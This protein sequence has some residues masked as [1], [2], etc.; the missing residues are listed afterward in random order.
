MV[1]GSNGIRIDILIFTR[2]S[3]R[4]SV[5][6]LLLSINYIAEPCMFI[7]CYEGPIEVRRQPL[8]H[9]GTFEKWGRKYDD[10]RAE[11]Y[12]VI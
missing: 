9:L 11:E 4:L 1:W 2:Y 12:N 7:G 8:L 10:Y 5:F 6:N 3:S